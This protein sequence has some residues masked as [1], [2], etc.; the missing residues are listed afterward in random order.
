V[1]GRCHF[2]CTNCIARCLH[3]SLTLTVL[4]LHMPRTAHSIVHHQQLWHYVSHSSQRAASSVVSR[5]APSR[6]YG[7]SERTRCTHM[8]CVSALR[9]ANSRLLLLLQLL[10]R[11]A[12]AG[13]ACVSIC[14]RVRT[15]AFRRR[16]ADNACLI[17][18]LH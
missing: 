13:K 8:Q 12:T 14:L 1:T 2:V 15:I 17:E 4:A 7:P 11:S 16:H 5:H 9:N 6:T 3:A 18:A 10:A